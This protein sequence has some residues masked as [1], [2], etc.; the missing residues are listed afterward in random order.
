MK[1]QTAKKAKKQEERDPDTIMTGEELDEELAKAIREERKKAGLSTR[2]LS[3]RIG[4][5]P[6][7]IHKIETNQIELSTPELGKIA[8]ALN[9]PTQYFFPGV[10]E[11]KLGVKASRTVKDIIQE[12]KEQNKAMQERIELLEQLIK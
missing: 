1:R 9:K 6:T 8:Q 10:I 3:R 7:Y 2:E 4:R 11:R 12:L 5:S